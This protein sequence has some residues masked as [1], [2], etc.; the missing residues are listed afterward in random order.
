MCITPHIPINKLNP[1]DLTIQIKLS[2]P[3][4]TVSGKIENCLHGIT[5]TCCW[6]AEVEIERKRDGPKFDPFFYNPSLEIQ[7][8]FS[9]FAGLSHMHLTYRAIHE[10]H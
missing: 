10:C 2:L 1:E 3:V 4:I 8:P 9:L 6:A 5:V 7:K